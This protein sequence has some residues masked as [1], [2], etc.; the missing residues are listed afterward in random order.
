MNFLCV[1]GSQTYIQVLKTLKMI[2]MKKMKN[3]I[4]KNIL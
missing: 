1:F 2:Y 3:K 4:P